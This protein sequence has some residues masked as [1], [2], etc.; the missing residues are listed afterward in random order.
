MNG[1]EVL[2]TLSLSLSLSRMQLTV[3]G[4]PS[5][6]I[7]APRVR[8]RDPGGRPPCARV[9]NFPATGSYIDLPGAVPINIDDD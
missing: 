3:P 8:R 9:R 7:E 6:T 5:P 4:L 2:L 1:P